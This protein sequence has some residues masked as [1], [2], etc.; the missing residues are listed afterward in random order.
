VSIRLGAFNN[1]SSTSVKYSYKVVCQRILFLASFLFFASVPQAAAV[2]PH[3]CL[4]ALTEAITKGDPEHDF[5]KVE[6]EYR[7][8]QL[9]FVEE[10]NADP[11]NKGTV[12]EFVPEFQTVRVRLAGD[13]F[14]KGM[15]AFF[16]LIHG[17]GSEKAG[18]QSHKQTM[19]NLSSPEPGLAGTLQYK[20]H[21][22]P[23]FVLAGSEAIAMP[24]SKLGPPREKFIDAEGK[25]DLEAVARY[26]SAYQEHTRAELP[27]DVVYIDVSRSS[28]G[29]YAVAAAVQNPTQVDGIFA[30]AANPP[31]KTAAD[32][33]RIE[34]GSEALR[35]QM[36]EE[37]RFHLL[38]VEGLKII[39]SHLIQHEWTKS[40]I[41]K[42][43]GLPIVFVDGFGDKQTLRVEKDAKNDLA[44]AFGGQSVQMREIDAGH[45][46][47]GT[48][49]R[50]YE[51]LFDL[52]HAAMKRRSGSNEP[53]LPE[54]IAAANIE[55]LNANKG[56]GIG[57]RGFTGEN[58]EPTAETLVEAVNRGPM[59]WDMRGKLVGSE[60]EALAISNSIDN[61][62][63]QPVFFQADVAQLE[64]T[65][66]ISDAYLEDARLTREKTVRDDDKRG[67]DSKL[68][69]AKE[70]LKIA[71]VKYAD[72]QSRS[73]DLGTPDNPNLLNL[74]SVQITELSVQQVQAN[75][76]KA[77]THAPEDAIKIAA[78]E[79][80]LAKAKTKAAE[81]A[82][83]ANEPGTAESPN[84]VLQTPL[85]RA[86]LAAKQAEAEFQAAQGEYDA[87]MRKYHMLADYTPKGPE[88]FQTQVDTN[89]NSK[90][91]AGTLASLFR[92]RMFRYGTDGER[93][94]FS[95]EEARHFFS[96]EGA[97]ARKRYTQ[98]DS[99]EKLYYVNSNGDAIELTAKRIAVLT[100]ESLP[101]LFT[102]GTDGTTRHYLSRSEVLAFLNPEN[103]VGRSKLLAA[104]LYVAK[105]DA[106]MPNKA[107]DDRAVNGM[108]ASFAAVSDQSDVTA[109]TRDDIPLYYFEDGK[110][111]DVTEA[112]ITDYLS[113]GRLKVKIL[114]EGGVM[115]SLAGW[116]YPKI[117]GVIFVEEARKTKPFIDAEARLAKYEAEGK[118]TRR[119]N[120]NFNGLLKKFQEQERRN[121]TK[122]QNRYLDP[123]TVEQLMIAYQRGLVDTIEFY[124]KDGN[125]LG[126]SISFKFRNS[127]SCDSVAYPVD[128][129]LGGTGMD[130][131][132]FQLMVVAATVKTYAAEGVKVI[133]AQQVSHLSEKVG[134]RYIPTSLF[135]EYFPENSNTDPIVLDLARFPPDPDKLQPSQFN[136]T[137]D[138][139]KENTT[140]SPEAA[141]TRVA[142]PAG[143]TN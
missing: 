132:Q 7:A 99:T 64:P 34:K 42:L 47:L 15:K 50:A 88:F 6:A 37:G 24:G 60:Q 114:K 5:N 129:S 12:A 115:L 56:K 92:V 33:L 139:A 53:S 67:A 11:A 137:D 44:A 13:R 21:N 127:F 113:L 85:Q 97:D 71:Q 35:Q 40:E 23:T 78:L 81:V 58:P 61:P 75:L 41:D 134:A 14:P 135:E 123:T 52:V 141:P 121:K 89:I 124:D 54:K 26:L 118:I 126:G 86:E 131:I 65:R 138:P 142:E 49:P 128:G 62:I 107:V 19:L 1:S 27:P 125:L 102:V 105:P 3:Q 22:L 83:K 18:P 143:V 45:D 116:T 68:E 122:K 63:H 95:K 79:E 130:G 103:E 66:H 80:K 72:M 117:R 20:V 70:K 106:K 90:N 51:I 32:K 104:G 76:E 16:S 82:A 96:P 73:Q 98:K 84:P 25:P 91:M 136:P 2:V 108:L 119:R 46:V 43:N 59:D 10:Y 120:T 101:P 4:V 29:L 8:R 93:I 74:N 48:S 110:R 109:F 55:K 28:G 69:K 36:M 87:F 30:A 94:Y 112:Q 111:V 31:G 100:G 57:P 17:M 77:K 38:D 140:D 133:D 9:K 39:D